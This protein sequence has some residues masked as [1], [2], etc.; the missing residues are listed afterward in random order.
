MATGTTS[1]LLQSIRRHTHLP[2]THPS[3]TDVLTLADATEELLSYL[4][5]LGLSERQELWAGPV[6]RLVFP[7]ENGTASYPIHPRAA[8]GKIRAARLLDS[9]GSPSY[10]AYLGRE[11]VAQAYDRTSV[12]YGLVV[13][14]GTLRLFPTPQSL[15]GYWVEVDIYIRP[16][17]LVTA[18]KTATVLN[19]SIGSGS[20]S[21]TA[22]RTTDNAEIFDAA[23]ELDVV[24]LTPPFDTKLLQATVVTA[25]PTGGGVYEL[26][27]DGEFTTLGLGD[28]VCLPGEAPVVQAP[29]EWHPLLA[30]K[31]ATRQLASLGDEG[32]MKMKGG[33]G[34]QKERQATTLIRPR[35]EDVARKPSN[36][37]DRWRSG[38]GW[39]Y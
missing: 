5:P 4:L 3:F 34:A 35:R 24:S 36:G 6:G 12:P 38:G 16:A 20:T 37:M 31:V 25:T 11:E 9:Q 2:A 33:E 14:G 10:L 8:G 32:G 18:E 7:V 23:S 39:G 15:T 1:A 26:L 13:E 19:V 28:Y 22:I 17:A 30:L 21:V 29:L 27:L